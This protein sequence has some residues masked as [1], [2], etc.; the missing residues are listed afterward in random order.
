MRS[1]TA[2][3]L[4][5]T[6]VG[7]VH[8]LYVVLQYVLRQPLLSILIGI[9]SDNAQQVGK[10]FLVDLSGRNSQCSKIIT[11]D[12]QIFFEDRDTRGNH[13][14]NL[15]HELTHLGGN[16]RLISLLK[17]TQPICAAQSDQI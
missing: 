4:L 5:S 6:S 12:S 2:L 14:L 13:L 16:H 3:T 8:L 10:D 1:I 11:I 7:I 9:I 15:I 17:I